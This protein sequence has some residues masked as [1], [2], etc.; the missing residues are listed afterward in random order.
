MNVYKQA[1]IVTAIALGFVVILT[2]CGGSGVG[3]AQSNPYTGKAYQGDLL[4]EQSRGGQDGIIIEH[5]EIK[6]D[7]TATGT[8]TH[9]VG[10]TTQ[11]GTITGKIMANGSTSLQIQCGP[12]TFRLNGLVGWKQA[13]GSSRGGSGR[14]IT[15]SM[16]VF[17]Q[18]GGTTSQQQGTLE[19]WLP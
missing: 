10:D 19:L 9:Q 2:G 16:T 3:V 17:R 14:Q 11:P 15:G 8:V 1:S 6:P 7:G 5:M 18:E 4:L 12:S 13:V